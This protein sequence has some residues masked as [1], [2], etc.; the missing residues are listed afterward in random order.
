[1]R[2]GAAYN[3]QTLCWSVLSKQAVLML[4]FKS[5]GIEFLYK[6]LREESRDFLSGATPCSWHHTRLNHPPPFCI[7]Q[8][9]KTGQ[10]EGLGMRLNSHNIHCGMQNPSRRSL[11]YLLNCRWWWRTGIEAATL[12]GLAIVYRPGMATTMCLQATCVFG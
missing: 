4:S 8:A 9:I 7:L 3:S 10:W 5:Y 2:G 6:I 1:M 12:Q 11:Y